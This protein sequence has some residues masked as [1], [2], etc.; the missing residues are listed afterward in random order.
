MLSNHEPHKNSRPLSIRQGEILDCKADFLICSGNPSLNMSG[1]V[2]GALLERY[3]E[4][5]QTELHKYLEETGN[6]SVHPGF[7]YRWARPIGDYKGVTYSVAIDSWYESS[8]ELVIQTIL[9][10][11]ELLRPRGLETVVFPALATG[12]G[13][14]TKRDFGLALRD[15]CPMLARQYPGTQFVLVDRNGPDIDEIK[16]ASG[17]S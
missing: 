13:K 3:G 6:R 14:L 15:L 4:P 8:Q 12:Y 7:C 1:G 10:S 16:D 5:L 11:L 9:H 2:N 17:F